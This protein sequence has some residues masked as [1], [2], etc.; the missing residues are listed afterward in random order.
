MA[1]ATLR[2]TLRVERPTAR[3]TIVH[4]AREPVGD[5]RAQE[6]Y[7]DEDEGAQ[8]RVSQPLYF[9]PRF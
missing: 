4:R 1:T 6:E 9:S 3:A 5:E 8:E 7:A 2:A